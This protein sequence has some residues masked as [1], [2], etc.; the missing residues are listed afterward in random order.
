M[1]IRLSVVI[2]C[3]NEARYLAGQLRSLEGQDWDGWWEVVVVDNVSTDAT[4]EIA[5]SFASRLPRLRVLRAPA[6]EGPNFASNVGAR[7]ASGDALLFLHGD[8]EVA[9]GYL[10]FMAEALEK[11]AFVAAR[12]DYDALNPPWLSNTRQRWQ[13]SGLNDAHRLPY[14]LGSTQALRR[15]VFERLGGFDET[16]KQSGDVD[17]SWRAQLGGTS[18]HFEPRA[19]VRYRFRE[20]YRDMYRQFRGYGRGRAA[21]YRRYGDRVMARRP[22]VSGATR[23]VGW[24]LLTAPRLAS[25]HWR[26]RWMCR[27]GGTVGW[28]QASLFP[29]RYE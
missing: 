25:R 19:V 11:H 20:S 12:V 24:L 13:T 10:R 3:R 26:A 23:A 7:E 9:P 6:G 29:Q 8:D 4:A 5:E 21:L 16:L 2:P 27:L 14:A 28:L 18:I 15:E 1:S 17:L 22:L